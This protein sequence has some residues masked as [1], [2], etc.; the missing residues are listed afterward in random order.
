MLV[1]YAPI[2]LEGQHERCIKRSWEPE[3]PSNMCYNSSFSGD[4]SKIVSV[5]TIVNYFQWGFQ[6]KVSV[7]AQG[8]TCQLVSTAV[9]IPDKI[10]PV[11]AEGGC[12]YLRHPCISSVPS[13]CS[14][15]APLDSKT[16]LLISLLFGKKHTCVCDDLR[17][18]SCNNLPKAAVL[19]QHIPP[20]ISLHMDLLHFKSFWHFNTTSYNEW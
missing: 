14:Y 12:D 18:Y 20:G 7:A 15:L 1:Y 17:I 6:W 8:A 3:K 13:C 2:D 5:A 9:R 19:F 11:A 16:K 4:P 10:V